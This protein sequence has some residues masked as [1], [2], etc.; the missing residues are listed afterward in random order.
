MGF[1]SFKTTDT[2]QSVSNVHSERG[3]L[4]VYLIDDQGN[5]HY[6]PNY[7]GYGLFG[8]VDIFILTAEMNGYLFDENEDPDTEY[9]K[10]RSL[11]IE[12]FYEEPEAIHPNI[13]EV[14]QE[15]VP[16]Q[17]ESCEFQGYFY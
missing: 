3:A 6:E 14:P 7:Q 9:E 5:Q 17:L 13:C 4:A 16:A 12:L 10:L 15:W 1:F 8:G 2:N 11:G